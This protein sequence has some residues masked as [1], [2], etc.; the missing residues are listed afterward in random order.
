MKLSQ[1]FGAVL[2][3]VSIANGAALERPTG[4]SFAPQRLPR[5]L[6]EDLRLVLSKEATISH[7]LSDAP[8]WSEYHRP[9]PGT[10]VNVQTEL[11]VQRVVRSTTYGSLDV[12]L[13]ELRFKLV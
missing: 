13:M 7:E 2:A 11:D 6:D 9:Q 4:P 8:R 10:I 12:W 5:A 3:Y 1:L